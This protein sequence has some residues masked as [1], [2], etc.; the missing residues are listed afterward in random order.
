MADKDQSTSHQDTATLKTFAH[1]KILAE[2]GRGGMGCVY[3]AFDTKLE[4]VVALKVLI[5]QNQ[6]NEKQMQRFLIEARATAKLIHPNIVRVYEIGCENG[7][8]FFTMDCIDGL[9]FKE[10][11]TSKKLNQSKSLT[12][13]KKVCEAMYY[14]HQNGIVHRDLKPA[15]IMIDKK[16]E[17]YV[18]DFG[19]AKTL[20]SDKKLSKTG[21]IMGTLLY[22]PPEQAEGRHREIDQRS[23]IYSLGAIVYQIVT[24][25]VPHYDNATFTLL[26]KITQ[27]PIQP[28]S[29]LVKSRQAKDLDYI[30]FKALAKKKVNRYE[31][32]K[33]LAQDLD[34]LII[35]KSITGKTR[36]WTKHYTIAIVSIILLIGVT[37]LILNPKKSID[38]K[39]IEK[40]VVHKIAE[41]SKITM[42]T[43]W[44]QS[45]WKACWDQKKGVIDFTCQT[46]QRFSHDEQV[47]H[48]KSYQLWYAQYKE[49][50][51]VKKFSVNGSEFEMILIPPGKFLMGSPKSDKNYEEEKQHDVLLSE[52]F[53]LSITEITEQQWYKVTAERP[54]DG[55]YGSKDNSRHAASYVSWDAV[56]RQFLP[57]LPGKFALPTEAQWEYACR[58]GTLAQFYWGDDD[59]SRKKI[60]DYAW[61]KTRTYND[62][63]IYVHEVKRKLPNSWGLYDMSGNLYEWCE[64]YCEKKNDKVVT[65]TYVNGSVN[66]I[67][68]KG[69]RRIIRGGYWHDYLKSC[70]SAFRYSEGNDYGL[71]YI[72]FRFSCNAS[73]P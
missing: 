9:S 73:E 13:M 43:G 2:L 42:P 27:D 39:I 49:L 71:S 15:N 7:I 1:F 35:G 32:A 17:P 67:C 44:K 8:A 59:R 36:R 66:P 65:D 12:I 70:Q 31:N 24:G 68:K 30:C 63:T 11:I 53:Y 22:M 64:D 25:R 40:S 38:K 54:W 45:S 41:K 72:G 28:P 34:S 47:K 23:D 37:Y 19:L 58:A 57:E 56:K 29:T 61:Y 20:N 69:S 60:D 5:S 52:A 33:K 55:E 3:K 4:R 46:W 62:I 48:A 10:M 16:G 26:K 14:A 50:D 18:M 21:M 51:L 6:A